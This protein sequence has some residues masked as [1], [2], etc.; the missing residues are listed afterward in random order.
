M[1]ALEASANAAANAVK[2]RV[3][4]IR[5]ALGLPPASGPLY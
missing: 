4:R 2:I 3:A 1:Q 5:G